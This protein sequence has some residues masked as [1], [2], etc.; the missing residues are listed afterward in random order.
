M[1]SNVD[2]F[3]QRRK[4][5]S[6]ESMVAATNS[7]LHD[8]KGLRE[9]SRLYNVPFET[10]RRR[11]NGTVVAGCKPGPSTILTEEEEDRLA[12]Y[13]VQMS[14]MGFGLSRDTVMHLA[15]TIVDKIQR[16]HPFK[17]GKAGRAWFDG[18]RKRHPKLTIRSPQPL[19]YCRALCANMDTM[20]DFF[21][22]LGSMYGRL[23]L[24]AKP[25]QVYNCDETGV[26]IVHK[27]G[28]VIA[29]LGRRNVYAVTSAER[30]KTHTV[31]SCV[32]A[33]G[34]TLPPMMV[35][36]RKKSV[37]E[38]FQEGA[39]PNTLFASSESGWMNTEL[40]LQWFN[41][42]LRNIP[43]PRPVLLVMDGHGSH[44]S[45]ELIELA[46]ANHV[47]LLCLPSHTTHIL[48]PL[49]VG[50][51]KS[52]K[53]NF[54][55]AC[56]RYLAA[57]PGRVI[58]NDKLA[59]LVAEAWPHSFTALNIMSGFKKCGVF[60]INPG[61]VTDRQVAPSKVFRQQTSEI[62]R[63]NMD[64]EEPTSSSSI[65]LFSPEKEALYRKRYEEQYDID[66][67]GFV[68]W[69]KINHPEAEVSSTFTESSTSSLVSGEQC[70]RSSERSSESSSKSKA[71]SSDVLSEVLVLPRPVVRAKSSRKQALNSKRTVCI[72]EDEV[73]ENL[74]LKELEKAEA[75]KEKEAK[76]LEK[77]QKAKER[78]E[79]RL[80]IE[81]RK[82]E[83]AEKQLQKRK[84]REET[85]LLKERRAKEAVKKTNQETV[86]KKKAGK[87][88]PSS[89]VHQLLAEMQ[90]SSDDSSSE[91]QDT[92]CPKCGLVYAD[93]GGL[94]VCCDGCNQWF[95]VKCTNIKRRNVPEF[96]YCEDCVS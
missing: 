19:S 64:S 42:F 53:S 74:K 67:P 71:S 76:A 1:A 92:I 96:Y 23:N 56:S 3:V 60:P 82:R 65:P 41:F 80:A 70:S 94:W 75:Q 50:V 57:N 90:L 13:L 25:M 9:A 15:Y 83:R 14:E 20:K 21:G 45:I 89:P 17:D 72:T 35:Y 6:E 84:E 63:Q 11:V 2:T 40:F 18:F 27:P 7:V 66:D 79:K 39:I 43:P 22:K 77:M 26:S 24:I 81:Q 37:P 28:K 93:S 10:L 36:P 33:S 78:E 69:L 30:G 47:H 51:F 95:D 38:K 58:T 34:Y 87:E 29:E 85:Q 55:K 73:L 91:S 32:S 52:F 61:E 4:L 46:R 68:A 12:R 31:L 5:W 54:S 48:Q 16:K 59:S 62:D 49:D 86:S 8:N 88:K 44:V